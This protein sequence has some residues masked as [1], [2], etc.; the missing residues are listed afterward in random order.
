[1]TVRTSRHYYNT[2]IGIQS[3]DGKGTEA[4]SGENPRIKLVIFDPLLIFF[5]FTLKVISFSS[6]SVSPFTSAIICKNNLSE[7]NNVTTQ[8]AVICLAC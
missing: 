2:A 3:Q 6:F 8:K 7:S 4:L 1:M 5:L